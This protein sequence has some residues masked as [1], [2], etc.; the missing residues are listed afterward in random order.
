MSNVQ[1]KFRTTQFELSDP[2]LFRGF[3]YVGGRWTAGAS[4]KMFAVSNPAD[5]SHLG[6]VASLSATD[7]ARAV[8]AAQQAFGGWSSLL[9]QQRSAILRR[10]Y[11]LIIEPNNLINSS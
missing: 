4:G 2:A 9:P 6:D 8:D 1:P 10:W 3:S 5:G 7:S 11:E